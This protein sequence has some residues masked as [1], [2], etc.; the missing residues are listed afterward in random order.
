[1]SDSATSAFFGG[2]HVECR[3]MQWRSEYPLVLIHGFGGTMRL[4]DDLVDRLSARPLIRYDLRG[5]GKSCLQKATV[6]HSEDLSALLDELD[7]G[8]C[9]I[10]G[11]SMG[12]SIALNFA[13]DH[14]QRVDKL[15]LVSPGLT[16]WEW[17]DEWRKHWQ[18]I[19]RL[20]REGDMQSARDLWI[21]HP[22]FA[23]TRNSLSFGAL[24]ESID[25]Y[26]GVHWLRDDLERAA[27]PDMERLHEMKNATH[28]VSG[29]RDIDEF[30]LIADIIHSAVPAC[31]RVDI[32]A[33]HMI[34]L[35]KPDQL[36]EII[37]D[38]LR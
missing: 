6:S 27:L 21:G 38:Y 3:N 23:S 14:P 37:C 36:A 9:N 17:S 25:E 18:E 22:L 10:V 13:L 30:R 12:G 4:W 24:R 28:L 31:T 33:G 26:S 32:D 20:A 2:I 35:E 11:C 29:R 8:V 34:P 5:F 15:I 19:A 1:M 7:I 16:A